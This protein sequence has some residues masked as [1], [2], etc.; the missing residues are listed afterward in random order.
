MRRRLRLV[1][2]AA[3]VVLAIPLT[4][5]AATSR[6]IDVSDDNI[7]VHDINWMAANRITRGCN[8]PGNTM[9]CPGDHVTRQQMAAF[10]HRLAANRVV[11]A[12]TLDGRDSTAFASEME[13]VVEV[14]QL[15]LAPY[16]EGL[17][18]A[19]CPGNKVPIG[20]GGLESASLFVMVD[21]Y[22]QS[23][24]WGVSWQNLS[25]SQK[26]G[27]VRVYAICV[28]GDVGGLLVAT[29]FSADLDS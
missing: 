29:P 25:G 13:Q 2:L 8:P 10:M 11:D 19:T 28:S 7:F 3:V 4:A 16:T 9:Y 1:L 15:T 5:S 14:R 6:F 24:G 20:G 26:T 12:G 17:V 18:T 27:K 23:D 22:P 21:N